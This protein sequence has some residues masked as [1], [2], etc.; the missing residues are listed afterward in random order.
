MIDHTFLLIEGRPQ[1]ILPQCL[2]PVYKE[3]FLGNSRLKNA[4]C[5]QN[6]WRNRT[7]RSNLTLNLT[8]HPN[9]TKNSIIKKIGLDFLLIV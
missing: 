6:P 3:T 5:K 4:L 7:K 8:T 9:R 1:F 2:R